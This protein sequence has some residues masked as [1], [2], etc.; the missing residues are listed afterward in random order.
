[1][2]YRRGRRKEATTSEPIAPPIPKAASAIAKDPAPPP[3]LTLDRERQ[4][5]LDRPHDHQHQQDREQQGGQQPLRP[6]HVGEAVTDVDHRGDQRM[7]RAI[8]VP[9]DGRGGHQGQRGRRSDLD[10]RN[11]RERD[12]GG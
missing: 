5:H 9:P 3:G 2:R 1:V 6:D 10:Q 4:Q 7:T 8:D 12:T 11:N